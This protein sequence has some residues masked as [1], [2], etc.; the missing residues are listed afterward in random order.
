[1]QRGGFILLEILLVVAIIALIGGGAY[2][3]GTQNND[4]Q[5]EMG[6]NADKKAEET[7]RQLNEQNLNQQNEIDKIKNRATTST[8]KKPVLE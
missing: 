7:I 8:D 5:V 3:K 2:F 1:M 4:S 6:I